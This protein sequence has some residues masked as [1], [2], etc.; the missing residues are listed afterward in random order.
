MLPPAPL[1]DVI[2][3]K[4][5]LVGSR[6][7]GSRPRGFVSPVEARVL[8]GIPYGD[9]AQDEASYLDSRRTGAA[10]A[11]LA[12]RVALARLSAPGDAAA[13][14]RR[15]HIVAADVDNVTIDEAL[16]AIFVEPNADRARV[17]HFVHP[18]ALNL[19]AFDAEFRAL[20]GKADLVLPDGIGLRIAAKI[21]GVAMKHN[22][23]G[24]DLL[25][26]LAARATREH[27]PLLFVGGADGVAAACRDMLLASHPGLTIPFVSHGF[28]DQAALNHVKREFARYPGAILLVGMG[29]PIQERWAW[30]HAASVPGLTVITV[31]GLFDFYSGRIPRAPA[32][33]RELGLEWLWRMKQEPRRLAKRYLLGNPL[34]LALAVKQ[35]ITGPRKG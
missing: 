15:P 7:D 33:W 28:L 11:K 29:S 10:D 30:S 14:D 5:P 13:T 24:T 25:P 4:A 18:H 2:L 9:L 31:G 21:L 1:T 32:E 8:L 17:V 6:L 19:A 34:F 16:D 27:R 12:I 22:V 3:G 20:I 35:K 23:N 26:P